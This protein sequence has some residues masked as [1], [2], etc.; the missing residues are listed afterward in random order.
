MQTMKKTILMDICKNL[1]HLT[2]APGGIGENL[3]IL[4]H[5]N[6]VCTKLRNFPIMGDDDNCVSG[7]LERF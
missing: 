1:S 6:P 5:D 7:K 3:S 2:S 4:H